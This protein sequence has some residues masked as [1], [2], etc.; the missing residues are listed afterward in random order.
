MKPYH[1]FQGSEQF[2]LNFPKLHLGFVE[3]MDFVCIEQVYHK[4]K[5]QSCKDQ[6]I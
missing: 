4:M 6:F 2:S 1:V 3:H 5:D